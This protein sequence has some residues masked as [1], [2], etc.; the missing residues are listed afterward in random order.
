MDANGLAAEDHTIAG[1]VDF[2]IEVRIANEIDNPSLCVRLGH[3]QLLCNHADVNALVNAAVR[4]KDVKARV[5]DEFLV[6]GSE[7]EVVRQDLLA[8]S[9]LLLGGLEVKLNEECI[10]KLGDGIVICVSFLLDDS[11]EILQRHSLLLVRDHCDGQVSEDVW[12]GCLDGIQVLVVE[13]EFHEQAASAGVVEE[14]EEAPVDEPCAL[15]Q[16]DEGR[17]VHFAVDDSLKRLHVGKGRF[18]SLHQNFCRKLTP[19]SG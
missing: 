18:P 5:F 10:E 1:G 13:E 11:E 15:L 19:E 14:D 17:C 9:Q 8:L 4:L 12:A 2:G 16:E 6:E 3:V 7:E